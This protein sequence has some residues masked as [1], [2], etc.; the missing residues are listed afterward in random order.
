MPIA[1]T[2]EAAQWGNQSEAATAL[3][4]MAARLGRRQ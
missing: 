4:Q 1:S 3:G 2:F